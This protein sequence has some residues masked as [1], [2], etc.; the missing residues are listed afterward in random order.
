M[1]FHIYTDR[2]WRNPKHAVTTEATLVEA[3]PPTRPTGVVTSGPYAPSPSGSFQEEIAD[4]TDPGTGRLVRPHGDLYFTFQ[5]FQVGQRLRVR[6]SAKREEF[7]V[8]SQKTAPEDEWTR[9]ANAG[10]GALVGSTGADAATPLSGARMSPDQAARVQQV[11]GALG[12]AD[13]AGVQVVHAEGAPTG[14]H[15]PIDRLGKLRALRNS[16]GLTGAQFDQQK[17]RILG[18]E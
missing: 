1:G 5:P 16:G 10:V 18:D 6:W 7:D 2:W 4:V 17:R 15:D 14:E 3:K 8:Y 13:V 11:L 9:E 12:L